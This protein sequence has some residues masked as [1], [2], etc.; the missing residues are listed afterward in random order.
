MY[1]G[2]LE[3]AKKYRGDKKEIIGYVNTAK[4]QE[5]IDY[6]TSMGFENSYH[7]DHTPMRP[8]DRGEI[9]YYA[10]KKFTLLEIAEKVN[11]SIDWVAIVCGITGSAREELIKT[12]KEHKDEHDE[13]HE[14]QIE[15][16]RDRTKGREETKGKQETKTKHRVQGSHRRKPNKTSPAKRTRKPVSGR[17]AERYKATPGLSTGRTSSRRGNSRE[18]VKNLRKSKD[19]VGD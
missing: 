17:N 16:A 9:L 11:R 18:I 13:R 12:Y 3:A 4:A 5:A 2:K 6:C 10:S 8:W 1:K 14:E 7:T 19:Y 15:N